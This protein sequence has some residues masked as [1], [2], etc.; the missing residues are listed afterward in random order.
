MSQRK[1]KELIGLLTT[2]CIYDN[3]VTMSREAWL[4][5]KLYCSISATT[6][7]SKGFPEILMPF[8]MD[9]SIPYGEGVVKGDPSHLTKKAK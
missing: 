9:L 7:A 1:R 5:G 4:D 6:M 8:Y 3:P 2:V